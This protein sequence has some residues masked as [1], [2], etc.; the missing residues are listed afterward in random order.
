MDTL[1]GY[2]ISIKDEK[3]DEKT[4]F[5]PSPFWV[6]FSFILEELYDVVH[7]SEKTQI[8]P[9]IDLRRNWKQQNDENTYFITKLF[10]P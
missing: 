2:Y 4:Y 3:Q 9:K 5:N 8:R 1:H 7:T 6:N 10:K